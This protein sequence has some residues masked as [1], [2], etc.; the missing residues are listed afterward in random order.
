MNVRL[1]KS[2][3]ILKRGGAE[4]HTK[5]EAQ[6]DQADNTLGVIEEGQTFVLR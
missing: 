6:L 3:S 1:A 4:K 2:R 5:T